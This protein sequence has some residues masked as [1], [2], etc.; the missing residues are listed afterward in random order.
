MTHSLGDYLCAW[1]S[2]KFEKEYEKH[3]KKLIDYIKSKENHD[4]IALD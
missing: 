4:N 1:S 2:E 3:T